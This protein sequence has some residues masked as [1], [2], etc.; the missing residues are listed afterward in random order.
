MAWKSNGA[1][2]KYKKKCWKWTTYLQFKKPIT[3]KSCI[4][5]NSWRIS[6][7]ILIVFTLNFSHIHSHLLILVTSGPPF[8]NLIT[9]KFWAIHI[10]VVWDHPLGH[11]ELSRITLLKR[12]D[13][14]WT[15]S[16]I[17]HCSARIRD[18]WTLPTRCWC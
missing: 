5:I 6:H 18:T 9:Y 15:R 16:I 7:I 3:D 11:G 4:F 14:P 8:L 13:S 1:N 12:T 17:Y 10:L 2:S